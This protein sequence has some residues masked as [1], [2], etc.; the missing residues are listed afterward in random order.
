MSYPFMTLITG[1]TSVDELK[2][3]LQSANLKFKEDDDVIIVFSETNIRNGNEIEDGTKSIVIDKHSLLP[4]VSQFNKIIYNAD[5][6]LYMK[7]KDWNEVT[8][9]Y[10]YE[11]TMIL[12]FYAF[13]KWYICTRKC[14]DARTSYWIK[15][16]SYYDL[17]M[18]AI[19]GKFTLEDLNKEFC[20]HFILLHHKNKNI[21]EYTK[22]GDQYKTV[23]LAMTTKISTFEKVNGF[24]NN[25]IIYPRE[26]KFNNLQHVIDSLDMISKNDEITHSI[27]MEGFIIEYMHEGLLTILKLQTK[28]YEYIASVKPNISNIDAMFLELYQ[29]NLL[30]NVAP[31]FTP[32]SRDVVVRVHNAMRTVSEELLSI[33]HLTRSHKNEALYER[34]P[35]SFKNILYMVHGVYLEKKTREQ[36][37]KALV[38]E[39]DEMNNL[40]EHISI[41]INDIYECLKK[42]ESYWLRKLFIDRLELLEDSIMKELFNCQ[43]FDAYVQGKLMM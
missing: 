36:E 40:K 6:V 24:I 29:K 30:V 5:A 7:D 19:H 32:N 41:T 4:L 43:N 13:E 20:Y 8:V 14:L 27:S 23:A 16:I 12:V 33:Y 34:L 17:F 31:Y 10:C 15:N 18:E 3:R 39:I 38:P 11:G 22:L 37:K 25:K 42:M 35:S 26:F 1:V 9:K 28:V 2:E 21:I